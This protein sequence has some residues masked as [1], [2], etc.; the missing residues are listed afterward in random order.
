M[1][2]ASQM[3]HEELKNPIAIPKDAASDGTLG[4]ERRIIFL[5]DMQPTTGEKS[6]TG[7]FGIAQANA[8]MGIYA[9]FIGIS[10][11]H[12]TNKHDNY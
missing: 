12:C 3:L 11:Y 2:A 6:P 7:L 1:T 9:T 5:T 10:S 4:E 8:R